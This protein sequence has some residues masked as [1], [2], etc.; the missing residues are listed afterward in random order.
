MPESTR[1]QVVSIPE[2]ISRFMAGEIR[3]P[4]YARPFQ[5]SVD[6]SVNFFDAVVR[7][8]PVVSILAQERAAEAETVTVADIQV[9]AP[10]RQQAWHIIDGTQR[11]TAILGTLSGL[12]HDERFSVHYDLNAG[13][14]VPG[15]ES[16]RYQA[17]VPLSSAIDPDRLRLWLS[18]RTWLAEQAVDESY[19]LSAQLRGFSFPVTIVHG[20][21]DA[22]S[23]VFERIN[24]GGRSLTRAEIA[25]ARAASRGASGAGGGAAA[26][27]E[28]RETGRLAGFGV[29]PDE[30]LRQITDAGRSWGQEPQKVL[31]GAISFMQRSAAI[32]HSRL[33]PRDDS[34]NV[35]VRFVGAYGRPRGRSAELLR[36]WVWRSG[37]DE[38]PQESRDPAV[39]TTDSDPLTAASSLLRTLPN[40]VDWKPD[41]S[42]VSISTPAG[43]L[44]ALAL[45]SKRPLLLAA[46]EE[47]SPT[48]QP[49]VDRSGFNDAAGLYEP[50]PLT[51]LLDEGREPMVPFAST[52]PAEAE[53]RLGLAR[54]L[55]HP[56]ASP[57]RLGRAIETCARVGRIQELAS[58]CIDEEAASLLRNGDTE[59]FLDHRRLTMT[60]VIA[61]HVQRH[62]RW[63]FPDGMGLPKLSDPTDDSGWE[64]P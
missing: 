9:D 34:L 59:N 57:S 46:D 40:R 28:L 10:R 43:R 14:V 13:E 52:L 50:V 12:S 1:W 56:P 16:G 33:V 35:V 62:A 27:A 31:S 54:F 63:G 64:A 5:W 2:I 22:A 49:S 29:L 6:Q 18:E 45:L 11:L 30:V 21:I 8:F 42:H 39:F 7:G 4:R 44:N 55:L 51:S 15:K 53:G 37:T 36:R 24:S 20:D 60:R 58:H 38:N 17:A 32:P 3:I 47:D 19:R 61:H 41:L 25:H 23:E 26:V 48:G